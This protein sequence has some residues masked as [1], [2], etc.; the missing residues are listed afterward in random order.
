M[1]W[2]L[3]WRISLP[4]CPCPPAPLKGG[5]FGLLTE[6]SITSENKPP[7]RGVGGQVSRGWGQV[8]GSW[9]APDKKKSN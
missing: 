7:F 2:E 8:Q 4:P 6:I 5:S 1:G 3:A 9:G